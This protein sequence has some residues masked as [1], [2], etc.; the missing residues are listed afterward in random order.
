LNNKI[1]LRTA[2]RKH[3]DALTA[4]K[5]EKDSIE[6]SNRCLTL[7]IWNHSVYHLFMGSEKNKEVD[8]SFLLSVVQGK[9]KQPVI[10]RIGDDCIL[11]HFLLTDQTPL[12]LNRWGIAEPLS[13]I[14][15][16][17]KQIDVVFVPLLVFDLQGHRI[18][19]GKG[20]YDRFLAQCTEDTLKIGLSFFEPVF[21]IEDIGA[22]DIPL[23][24][25]VTPDKVF[26]F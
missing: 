10:P 17:P 25:V 23:N 12:K 15:L 20:Y 8:T 2:Y 22:N 16:S 18:G 21:R 14:T 9:D 6:I 11:E 3:R 24:Y 4:T 13:G 1:A 19:Y 5:I 26:D 7:D